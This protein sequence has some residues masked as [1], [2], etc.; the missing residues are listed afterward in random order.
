MGYWITAGIAFLAGVVAYPVFSSAYFRWRIVHA[1]H[2]FYE[3][4]LRDRHPLAPV[5]A[6]PH[7]IAVLG[8]Y[9]AEEA[10]RSC[11]VCGGSGSV[12]PLTFLDS[13]DSLP[14]SDNAAPGSTVFLPCPACAC[15]FEARLYVTSF[16]GMRVRADG[17]SLDDTFQVARIWLR[18]GFID[19]L[20]GNVDPE[21]VTVVIGRSSAF[22]A[23]IVELREGSAR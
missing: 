8:K 12:V 11:E 3:K 17:H 18:Y 1:T 5:S 19:P 7:E 4:K 9:A 15:D 21:N 20:N 6:T 23:E 22:G 16:P 13:K 10:R 14:R 2:Q